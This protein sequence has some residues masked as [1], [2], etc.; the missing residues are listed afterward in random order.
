MT[1]ILEQIAAFFHQD[2]TLEFADSTDIIGD[3]LSNYNK[4]NQATLRSE[5]LDLVALSDTAMQA[6]FNKL[7]FAYAP[8]SP[9][10]LR[11]FLTNIIDRIDNRDVPLMT[12]PKRA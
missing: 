6:K 8:D 2:F 12:L 10:G 3:I 4:A 1:F 11:A 9:E 7:G 5:L